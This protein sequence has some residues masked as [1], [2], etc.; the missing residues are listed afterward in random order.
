[1]RK[2]K[3]LAFALAVI[4]VF[5]MV[6]VFASAAF[7]APTSTGVSS[8]ISDNS[9]VLYYYADKTGGTMTGALSTPNWTD[10]NNNGGVNIITVYDGANGTAGT[11][12]ANN[13]SNTIVVDG[14]S[15]SGSQIKNKTKMP[16]LRTFIQH[17]IPSS[18]Q[19]N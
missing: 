14:K 8:I 9:G 15:Y 7:E 5:S 1:M 17:S 2:T 10:G 4:M 11:T 18:S 12:I 16:T 3:I 6:S 13:N 19:S